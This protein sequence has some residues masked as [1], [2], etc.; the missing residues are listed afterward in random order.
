M[1]SSAFGAGGY[2]L[3]VNINRRHMKPGARYIVIELARR[4]AAKNLGSKISKKGLCRC[5]GPG[6]KS[7]GRLVRLCR[8]PARV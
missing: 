5:D 4:L 6:K 8:R 2:A 7:G 3:T 1:T